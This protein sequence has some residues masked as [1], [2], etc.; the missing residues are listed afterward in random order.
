MDREED[1]FDNAEQ[2]MA[3]F[4]EA[5]DIK[6]KEEDPNAKEPEKKRVYW[7]DIIE[8]EEQRQRKMA[9]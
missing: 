7:R 9:E 5:F 1:L 3:E 4:D 8:Q 6:F 2:E